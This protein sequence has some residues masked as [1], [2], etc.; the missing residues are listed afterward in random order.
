M[1]FVHWLLVPSSI[2]KKKKNFEKED[3][4]YWS[5]WNKHWESNLEEYLAHFHSFDS[6]VTST[7]PD[8]RIAC[9]GKH[10]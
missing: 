7:H 1:F 8:L 2:H 5:M 6:Q 10:S 3:N 4:N 9:Y